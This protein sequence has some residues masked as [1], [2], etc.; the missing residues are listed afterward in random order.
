MEK[1]YKYRIYPNKKQE[2]LIHKTFGCTR[3]IYNYF[4]DLRI[5][6]YDEDKT[7]FGYNAMSKKLTSLKKSMFGLE[8]LIKILYKK[9]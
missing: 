3:F 6:K 2:E 1:A 5:K 4:L 7:N 8:N 9:L